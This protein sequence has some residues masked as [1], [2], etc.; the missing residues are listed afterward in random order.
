MIPLVRTRLALGLVSLAVIGLE[1]A[2]MRVLSLLYWSHFACMVISV[3]LLGFGASGTA[4]TLLRRI[5]LNRHRGWLC[6]LAMAFSLSVPATWWLSR[7]VSLDVQFLAWNLSQVGGAIAIELLMFVP[8]FLAGAMVGVALMDQPQRISG[9]YAANLIGSGLGAVASVALMYVFSTHGLLLFMGSVG[10]LAG[11]LLLPWRRPAA[12]ALGVIAAAALVTAAWLAPRQEAMSP[13]KM[14]SQARTWPG[15]QVIPQAEGPLGRIDVVAGPAVHYAPGLSLQYVDALPPHVLLIV[16][17]DQ[18]S[19]VYDCKRAEDWVFLDYS[20]AAAAY[21]L[22]RQPRVCIIGAG[23]GADIGLAVF[24]RSSEVVAL[25][26]NRQII[27]AMTGPLAARG[28][29]IYRAPGVN[30]VNQE[31][32]GYFASAAKEFDIIQLPA[33][34]AFGASGAGLY[35]T[36]ESYLYTAEALEAMLDR[37]GPGGVLSITR[38]ARMPPREELRVF[39]MAAQALLRRRLDPS[40]HL[41]MIRSWVT[42][43][44]LVFKEPIRAEEADAVRA[45]CRGRSFDLCY[46]P[47]VTQDEVNRY[48]LL[49][50]P[51][52]LQ[53]ARSL[54]GPRREEFLANYAFEVACATDEKPYFFHSFRWRSLGVL[55]GQ[56]GGATHAFLEVGY[57]MLFAAL[58][59]T[60]VM[61]PV[62]ILLPLAP[63]IK[64]I[65]H[66]EGK[67]AALGYFL[68]LGVGF[69]LLEMGFLQKF[70]LYLA[71]PIYSAA[72]VIS[73]FLVFAGLGSQLSGHWRLPLK[74][75]ASLA[76][77]TVVCLS[78]VYLFAM[79]G[80]LT[81]TQAQAAPVRFAIAAGTIA[82]LALAMGHMFP[83]GLR[84]VGG[85]SPALVPWAWA[86]NAFASVV[87]TAAAPLLAMNF[88]FSRVTLCAIAC[89]ALAGALCQM[90]GGPP[91]SQS[92]RDGSSDAQGR[93]AEVAHGPRGPQAT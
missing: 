86:V 14:L 84:Q 9:H 28:G 6:G 56:L 82:P 36:Q 20:T 41:A 54:L 12:A 29:S 34:D 72:L 7:H 76:A 49:D 65:R 70:I 46:L 92:H 39:D 60:L 74:H 33:I 77:G 80:W 45:F 11:A 71:H 90:L 23:G 89:Y 47:G 24:H 53:A 13:Y 66:A 55:A 1:L 32:R 75:V 37:L 87:A 79:D 59:Q 73:S 31:A 50:Q 52:Y 26:M 42:V 61:A 93:D 44:V 67:G 83:T 57:L 19:A 38:W 8:F 68:L 64:A 18:T 2:L 40:A 48:H 63:G 88:G 81:W 3:A 5:I 10:Y 43:T 91:R 85:P 62:L 21:H 58:A 15:T 51:Y 16:D 4:I 25:E 22:R 30:V 69:M 78:A 35:A 17:G 27:Q